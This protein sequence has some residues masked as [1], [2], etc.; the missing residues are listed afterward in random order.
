MKIIKLKAGMLKEPGSLLR[1]VGAVYK[2]Q[3]FPSHA[4]MNP[5]DYKK[6]M[7]NYTRALKKDHPYMSLR[8]LQYSVNSHFLNL[9]PREDKGV[10]PGYLIV[11]DVE[12]DCEKNEKV[13][14][15]NIP[16]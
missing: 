10:A 1:Q 16:E 14:D 4:Y 2:N 11:D 5:K 13:W 3:A 12:I 9:G 8:T 15:S 7:A 6:L